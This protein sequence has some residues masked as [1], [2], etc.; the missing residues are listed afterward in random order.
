MHVV[1]VVEKPWVKGITVGST[2]QR[3]PEI[4]K[5]D[6]EIVKMSFSNILESLRFPLV[7][8]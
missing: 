8:S 3:R 4:T 1:E 7:E 6:S 2:V 5:N